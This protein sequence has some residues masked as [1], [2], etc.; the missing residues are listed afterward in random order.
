MDFHR[1]LENLGISHYC[2]FNNP[3]SATDLSMAA[4]MCTECR[5]SRGEFTIQDLLNKTV[6]PLDIEY[7]MNRTIGIEDEE[8]Q[9]RIKGDKPWHRIYLPTMKNGQTYERADC[10]AGRGSGPVTKDR[11]CTSCK[12]SVDT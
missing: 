6:N 8:K 11:I 7:A 10:F 9:A 1:E 12:K 3:W 5:L 4:L 2:H